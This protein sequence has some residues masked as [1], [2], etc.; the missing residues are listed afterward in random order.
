MRP[1]STPTLGIF[2][3]ALAAT[4]PTKA[5]AD[6]GPRRLPDLA[7]LVRIGLGGG[8]TTRDD[9]GAAFALEAQVGFR[10][11]VHEALGLSLDPFIG[12]LLHVG[13]NN[14]QA[15]EVGTELTIE[16]LAGGGLTLGYSGSVVL[17]LGGN[18]AT[19]G[20]RH[21]PRAEIV[22]FLGVAVMHQTMSGS[23]HSSDSVDLTLTIDFG[24][25][26]YEAISGNDYLR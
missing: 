5:H 24:P 19:R 21:G 4:T 22:N 11:L 17:E 2:L 10:C 6:D 7:P 14:H 16:G 15:T 23:Y 25:L 26:L 1:F 20:I 12:Y 9:G 3:A 8:G 18:D 13:P